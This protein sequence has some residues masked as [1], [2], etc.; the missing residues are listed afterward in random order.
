MKNLTQHFPEFQDVPVATLAYVDASCEHTFDGTCYRVV[1]QAPETRIEIEWN[2]ILDRKQ[3]LWPRFPAGAARYDLTTVICPCRNGRI[4]FNGELLDG[5][6]RTAQTVDG[7]LSS[8]AFLAFAE[9]WIGPL[10]DNE[11]ASTR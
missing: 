5:E 9:T 6:V 10:D 2:G 8:T 7:H 1:C 4:Q 3:I 11:E